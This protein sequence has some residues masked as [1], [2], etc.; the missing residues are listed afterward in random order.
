[1]KNMLDN[2]LRIL[3]EVLL[4]KV[5]LLFLLIHWGL[6]AI[7][8][9]IY[10]KRNGFTY[11]HFTYEPLPIQALF[12][13]DIPAIAIIL[14]IN[15]FLQ[16]GELVFSIIAIIVIS[17]QWVIVGYVIKALYQSLFQKNE[18]LN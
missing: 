4:N 17:V 12:I 1:M 3:K 6:F 14:L 11:F 5:S 16:A 13:L 10:Y 2:Y 15:S 9:Y 7:A 8:Y 18:G